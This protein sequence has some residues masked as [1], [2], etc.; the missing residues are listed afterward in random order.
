[1][2]IGC[3]VSTPLESVEKLLYH[4]DMKN[5]GNSLYRLFGYSVLYPHELEP[6]LFQQPELFK[7]K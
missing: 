2:E 3:G 4:G 5:I 7:M 1:V 6:H